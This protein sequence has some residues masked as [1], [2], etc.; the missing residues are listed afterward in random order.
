MSVMR[1]F[2]LLLLPVCFVLPAS[3]ADNCRESS[4][5]MT[6]V[7]KCAVR[8]LL[9]GWLNVTN[10]TAVRAE[11]VMQNAT[12]LRDRADKV[13]V[14]AQMSL[15]AAKDV[16]SRLGKT[17]Y[18]KIDT[19]VQ[20]VKMLESVIVEVNASRIK[21]ERAKNNAKES[22]DAAINGYSDILRAAKV[23]AGPRET[24]K[25]HIC[26]DNALHEIGMI[27]VGDG[28][29]PEEVLV[30]KNLTKVVDKLDVMGNL[31]EW[32]SEMLESLNSTYVKITT[33]KSTCHWTFNNDKEKFQHMK[34]TINSAADKLWDA[35]KEFDAADLT[36]QEAQRNVTNAGDEVEVVKTTMHSRFKQNGVAL[37]AMLGWRVKLGTQLTATVGRLGDTE[38]HTASRVKNATDLLAN[39]IE[40][41]EVVQ[42]VAGAISQLLKSG[43]LPSAAKLF[44]SGDI[45][46]ANENAKRFK[47]AATLSA[48]SA[49]TAKESTT[50]LE[51][52]ME[53]IRKSSN[54]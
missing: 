42:S 26:Y 28:G 27:T 4:K 3:R 25:I 15:D 19:V 20:T 2:L 17:N 46:S 40:T 51:V 35:L 54:V 39:A 50:E 5:N 30:S 13:K 41:N 7:R 22:M 31:S 34:E 14:E 29:C 21:A 36:L 6:D 37:C 12:A 49:T 11:K 8:D 47:D 52:Q 33:N 48:Q 43:P 1:F 32:K 45:S 24:E 9:W 10:K 53:T 44:A 38:R 23:I 16:L 18:E